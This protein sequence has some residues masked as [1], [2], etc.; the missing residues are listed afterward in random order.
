MKLEILDN[1]DLKKILGKGCTTATD[2][3]RWDK[4]VVGVYPF[5]DKA[6]IHLSFVCFS[7]VLQQNFKKFKLYF[8]NLV[9]S[10]CCRYLKKK[11]VL[12]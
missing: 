2:Y 10:S 12:D 9:F 5:A 8:F 7:I 6:F 1:F 3:K 11:Y 4:E